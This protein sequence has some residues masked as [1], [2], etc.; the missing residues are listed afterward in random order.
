MSIRI[1]CPHCER[2]Y[3]LADAQRG[4]TI[5]CKNCQGTF[6]VEDE[7]APPA[8]DPGYEAAVDHA[9]I[10]E[11]EE[12]IP[13]SRKGLL[14][15]LLWLIGWEVV[16]LSF[17]IGM[18]ILVYLAITR[19]GVS[20]EAII[21]LAI[22][23]LATVFGV[24]G[25]LASLASLRLF[26]LS[27]IP[28][29]SHYLITADRLRRYSRRGEVLEEI[30]F[31]NIADMRLVTRRLTEVMGE[32]ADA[33]VKARILHINLR[34]PEQKKTVLD[35]HF[36][37]WSRQVHDTDLALS[38]DFMGVPIK[39]VYKKIKKRWQQW[40]EGGHRQEDIGQYR[41]PKR[42]RVPWY[43]RPAVIVSGVLG[44]VALAGLLVVLIVALN[45]R[46]PGVAQNP[47]PIQQLN[48][49]G[50]KPNQQQPPA[51]GPNAKHQLPGQGA[52]E[53]LAPATI[54][55]LIAYW[56]L[57][58]GQG[59]ITIDEARKQPAVRHGGE[60]VQGIKG[61]ALRF[62]GTSDFLDLRDDARL[63]FGRGAPFTL[64]GWVATE[65]DRGRFA[66]FARPVGLA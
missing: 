56:P 55:G 12:E 25:F 10:P 4:K 14:L 65:T 5:R 41:A 35:H 26:F 37:R 47:N 28:S 22:G 32:G 60:W 42:R 24:S 31:G 19:Q 45:A 36:M 39:T 17:A 57:N 53:K 61:S 48:A 16:C 49:E 44:L 50:P 20:L 30:P 51:D 64:A 52:P 43:Q 58:E 29:S 18:P 8:A 62:N 6:K 66:P 54:P 3:Q 11:F 63:N 23:V 7:S 15:S 9:P 2:A 33:D 46:E 34:S 27:T 59:A 38:E 40:Q 21:P 1:S 13:F